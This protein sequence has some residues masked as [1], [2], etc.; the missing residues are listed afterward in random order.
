MAVGKEWTTISADGSAR[1]PHGKKT[2]HVIVH[3]DKL[4]MV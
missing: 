2:P 4:K 1:Y 3:K